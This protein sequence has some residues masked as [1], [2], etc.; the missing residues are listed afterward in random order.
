LDI[1]Q[2]MAN[3]AIA[4]I[5]ALDVFRHLISVPVVEQPPQVA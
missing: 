5:D 2:I 1:I 3:F 4:L